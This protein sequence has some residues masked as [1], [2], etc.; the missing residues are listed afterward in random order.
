MGSESLRLYLLLSLLVSLTIVSRGLTQG[1]GSL[2]QSCLLHYSCY[3][4]AQCR[5]WI[6]GPP[7]NEVCL[8]NHSADGSMVEKSYCQ[9]GLPFMIGRGVTM[10]T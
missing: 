2:G 10:G 4:R 1:L 7:D 6:P 3:F 8:V 9:D 5:A